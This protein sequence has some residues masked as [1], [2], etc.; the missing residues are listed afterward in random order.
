MQRAMGVLQSHLD[1][2]GEGVDEK[3]LRCEGEVES[4]LPPAAAAKGV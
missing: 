2:F 1:G 4:C 3:E